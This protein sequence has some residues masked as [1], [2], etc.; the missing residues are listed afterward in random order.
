MTKSKIVISVETLYSGGAESFAIRLANSL[1]VQFEVYLIV[2]QGNLVDQSV[3][4]KLKHDVRLVQIVFLFEWLIRKFDSFLLL[5][6]LDI[7]IR[8]SLVTDRVR[9]FLALKG[10][11]IIHSNQ[12][13]VDLIFVNANKSLRIRHVITVHGDYL[14][15]SERSKQKTLRILNF[16]KKA[17]MVFDAVDKIVYISDHQMAFIN[18]EP[19]LSTNA[20]K[21]VKIYNGIET[22][23][24]HMAPSN[25][26]GFKRKDFVFGMVARG[27]PE[28]GWEE[29][30]K[31]FLRIHT[32][33]MQLVLVGKSP[34][35]DELK[36]VFKHED[37]HFAGYSE[38]P[39]DWIG[40]FDVGLLPSTFA[41][42]SLPTSVIEY[43]MMGKPVIASDKGEIRKMLENNSASC[44]IVLAVRDNQIA[45][46]ELAAAM[47]LMWRDKELYKKMAVNTKKV[48][49]HFDIKTCVDAYIRVYHSLMQRQS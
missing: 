31:S 6:G 13:K 17:K 41:S 4:K 33:S 43:L 30:I 2:T 9:Q 7:S 25:F 11:D 34:Y 35:L 19:G 15:F 8:N 44:G 27:I 38:N 39:M 32:N 12:F 20:G 16:E 42:E 22:P 40:I 49:V 48:A 29:A 1:C 14:N 47:E 46:H 28:K 5:L 21:A 10:I 45:E 23:T 36:K 18:A 37:I 3:A 26:G 24:E